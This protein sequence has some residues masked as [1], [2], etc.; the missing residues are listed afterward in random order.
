MKYAIKF[1]LHFLL[2]ICVFL[3]NNISTQAANIKALIIICDYYE[4]PAYA[5]SV[6]SIRVDMATVNKFLDIIQLRDIAN[7]QRTLLQGKSA[8]L[9]NIQL[10]IQNMQ[11]SSDDI[12]L[13][14]YSGH[15]AMRQNATYLMTSDEKALW[16]SDLQAMVDAKNARLKLVFTEA[17]SNTTDNVYYA[18]RSINTG[19]SDAKAGIHDGFYKH[20]F[21]DY[22][23]TL[24]VSSSSEGE[25]A[26]SDNNVGG[27]FTHYFFSETLIKD[28]SDN[29]KDNVTKA[30][31]KTMQIFDRINDEMKRELA[32]QHVYSQIPKTYSEPVL[33]NVNYVST[34]P[35]KP[36]STTTNNS[37]LPNIV[38]NNY[39]NAPILVIMDRNKPNAVWQRDKVLTR[40]IKPKYALK[41]KD[42]QLLLGFHDGERTVYYE[43]KKGTFSLKN[44]AYGYVDLF[45]KKPIKRGVSSNENISIS[46]K[47]NGKW[48]WND[49]AGNA[50]ETK[51][52]NNGTFIDYFVQNAEA[53]KGTWKLIP[54]KI[55]NR[56]FTL[57]QMQFL[58]EGKA[59]TFEYLMKTEND[60]DD[61]SLILYRVLE[62]NI[63]IKRDKYFA[64]NYNKIINMIKQ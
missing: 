53:T 35:Q 50:I 30:R 46:E 36:I 11:T 21:N 63:E 9:D 2:F 4:D 28:P 58:D 3:F 24:H 15:G 54:Q 18:S 22:S 57:L 38:I 29:W 44:D 23:G 12:F 16:R 39:T 34:V 32:A 25:Y 56:T 5:A 51:F 19:Y 20:L 60:S 43:I 47:L 33:S 59:N 26:W 55:G 1:K 31:G 13:V 7:V 6:Q 8:T 40:S 62:N 14:Y 64:D 45:V 37:S 27:F 17:C 41:L 48:N 61:I 52:M 42:E 10:A 49:V